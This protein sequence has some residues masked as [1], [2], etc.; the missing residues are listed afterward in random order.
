M[1]EGS[2]KFFL[3][4]IGRYIEAVC[5]SIL[6]LISHKF[7]SSHYL[8]TFF[9]FFD[10]LTVLYN[11]TSESYLEP[12]QS[13]GTLLTIFTKSLTE[14]GRLVLKCISAF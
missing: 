10:V 2:L 13:D 6:F 14:D 1:L 12:T 8:F 7:F 3:D 11:L 9:L 4:F 5:F